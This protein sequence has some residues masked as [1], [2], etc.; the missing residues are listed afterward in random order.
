M[1]QLLSAESIDEN[2]NCGDNARSYY[3]TFEDDTHRYI[4]TSGI[5]NHT[6][7]CGEAQSDAHSRCKFPTLSRRGFLLLLQLWQKRYPNNISPM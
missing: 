5:P 7:E 3:E 4:I 2:N 1:E 6:M